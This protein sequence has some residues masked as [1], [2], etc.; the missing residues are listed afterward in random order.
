MYP[1]IFLSSSWV[2]A[3]SDI[4][5]KVDEEID[6]AAEREKVE[7]GANADAVDNDAAVRRWKKRMIVVYVLL[8]KGVD[9]SND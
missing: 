9:R 1:T 8:E 3:V 6:A 7:V 5:R 4:W 2:N